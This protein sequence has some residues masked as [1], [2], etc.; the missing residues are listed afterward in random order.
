MAPAAIAITA[1]TPRRPPVLDARPALADGRDA[2]GLCP[3]DGNGGA[4]DV[5]AQNLRRHS[6]PETLVAG[7]ANG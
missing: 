2:G 3:A 6:P 1:L 5:M 7:W 4:A